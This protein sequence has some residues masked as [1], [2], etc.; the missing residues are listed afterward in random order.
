MRFLSRDPEYISF[1]SGSDNHTHKLYSLINFN[2]TALKC[3]W[4]GTFQSMQCVYIVSMCFFRN[5]NFS[6]RL[7]T[8]NS[9]EQSINRKD[10]F[11]TRSAVM[12]FSCKFM[13]VVS[14]NNFCC[15]FKDVN[16]YNI[17]GRKIVALA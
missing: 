15:N 14:Q 3:C 13:P 9:S 5:Y 1:R 7:S 11:L 10:S 2:L 6:R 16:V 12:A 17:L 4:F 8:R